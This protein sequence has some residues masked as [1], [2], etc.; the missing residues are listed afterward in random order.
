MKA[1]IYKPAKTTMQSGRAKTAK[2]V[3]EYEQETP[4]R[5][6]P[7]M[8]WTSTEETITQVVLKFDSLEAAKTFAESKGIDCVVEQPATRK[9]TPRSYLDN[10]KF[11]K[12]S[13]DNA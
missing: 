11:R 6:E 12:E 9:V 10:F 2:W 7:M 8:G 13:D 4:R 5:I 1:R 3:L